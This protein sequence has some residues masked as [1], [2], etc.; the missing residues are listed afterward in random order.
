MQTIQIYAWGTARDKWKWI[1][2]LN[3]MKARNTVHLS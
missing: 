1:Q 2:K 3:K